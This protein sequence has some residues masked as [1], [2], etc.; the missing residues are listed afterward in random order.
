M[1]KENAPISGALPL[2]GVMF[3]GMPTTNCAKKQEVQPKID[4]MSQISKVLEWFP[5]SCL[6]LYLILKPDSI[7]DRLSS[8]SHKI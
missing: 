3:P 5:K 4:Q 1:S 8:V 7:V 6:S 2:H